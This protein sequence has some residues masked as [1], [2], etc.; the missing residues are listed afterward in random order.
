[1]IGLRFKFPSGTYHATPWQRHVNEAEVEWPP[2]PWRILRS[3]I[4]VWHR[5]GMSEKYA[6]ESFRTIIGALADDLPVYALPDATHTATRHYMPIAGAKTT[7]VYDAFLRVHHEAALDVL[8][9]HVELTVEQVALLGDLARRLPYLGRAESWV[10]ASVI[11]QASAAVNCMPVT[12][13]TLSSSLAA[14]NEAVRVLACMTTGEYEGWKM[15]SRPSDT[16]NQGRG[17]RKTSGAP[18]VSVYEALHVDTNDL[19]AANLT[20]PPGSKWVVY[21]RASLSEKRTPTDIRQSSAIA[22]DNTARFVLT[23]SPLPGVGETIEVAEVLHLALLD[24]F[25]DDA[26]FVLTGR[27]PSGNVSTNG[28]RHV[29][30]LPEDVDDDG[31]I[32]HVILHAAEPWSDSVL[33]AIRSI[34]KL[35]TPSWWPGRSRTWELFLEGTFEASRVDKLG[36]VTPPLLQ[37]GRVWV[38]KTPYLHPWYTKKNGMYGPEEQLRKDLRLR[39]LPDPAHVE[40]IDALRVN[41]RRYD[42]HAFQRTRR[43]KRQPLPDMVGSFWRVEFPEEVAGPIALGSNCHFGMGVFAPQHL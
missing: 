11:Q 4:A 32:D 35:W 27:D 29:F 26:P 6:E 42:V 33:S 39:G 24:R 16:S 10:D 1:M 28:H 19:Q 21:S 3:L 31:K 37:H 22:R 9:H 20:Q 13:G 30:I 40:K 5:H 14:G 7:L 2:A 34:Q 8:W 12:A 15:D 38:S 23:S 41:H 43:A 25:G 17:K 36:W 18:P